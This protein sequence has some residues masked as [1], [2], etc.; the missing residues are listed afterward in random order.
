MAVLFDHRIANKNCE[1]LGSFPVAI[2]LL[3]N[4]WVHLGSPVFIKAQFQTS[5]VS[6]Y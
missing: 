4:K 3:N 6:F 2:F 5:L 1:D